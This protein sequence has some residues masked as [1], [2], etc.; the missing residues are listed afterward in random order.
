MNSEQELIDAMKQKFEDRYP[1]GKLGAH[2]E[3]V[4]NIRMGID[5]KSN[6]LIIDFGKEVIWI[7]MSKEQAINFAKMI[8]KRCADHVVT[9]EIPDP[10][11]PSPPSAPPTAA[12]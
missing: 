6:N 11:E 1:E 7:G 8:L 10:D 2:D 12:A 9:M 4:L 3:G 5:P